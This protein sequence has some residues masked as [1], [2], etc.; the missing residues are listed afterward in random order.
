MEKSCK[1]PDLLPEF[2]RR[3]RFDQK[4]TGSATSMASEIDRN[5]LGPH[6]HLDGPAKAEVG[7]HGGHLGTGS[8][9]VVEA[10]QSIK[11]GARTPCV[12]WGHLR[13]WR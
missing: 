10:A 13:K 5:K 11:S 3:D 8:D 2:N 9:S 4:A 1:T 6:C 12:D 7:R